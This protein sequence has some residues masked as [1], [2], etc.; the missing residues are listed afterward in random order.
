LTSKW[1]EKKTKEERKKKGTQS[2][3]KKR[4]KVR[5]ASS[6][7]LLFQRERGENRRTEPR[8]LSPAIRRRKGEKTEPHWEEE[9]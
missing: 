7:S 3:R 5:N 6:H 4:T 9:E 1:R 2:E 8:A